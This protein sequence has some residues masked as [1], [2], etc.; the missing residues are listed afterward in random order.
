MAERPTHLRSLNDAQYSAVTHDP[1]V[2]LQIL[3]GPGS[4]KTRTLTYRIAHIIDVH[5]IPPSNIVAVTF[6]NKAANELRVRL[7]ALIG[8]TA[9][10]SLILGTFHSICGRLLRKHGAA[11]Q[12]PTNFSICD[13]DESQKII[14]GILKNIVASSGAHASGSQKLELK[15]KLALE[16]IS[17]AKAK[18]LD[19]EQ[20]EAKVRRDIKANVTVPKGEVSPQLMLQLLP[21]YSEYIEECKRHNALDFD[22]LLAYGVKLLKSRPDCV[23]CRHVF[24]DEFQDTNTIQFELMAQLAGRKGNVSVV[25]DPDQSIYGWRSA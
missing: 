11:I 12:V 14:N 19:P 8:R 2:P 1:S 13:A 17:K 20:L 18:G 25:G 15:D 4:G 23:D 6:T 9:S 21:V 16:L 7:D 5:G 10:S 3:A 22:D 24:V